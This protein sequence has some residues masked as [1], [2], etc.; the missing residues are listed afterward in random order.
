MRTPLV[1]IVIPAYNAEAYVREA[2]DSALAQ[3]YPNK[4]VIVVDDGS[5]DGTGA[6][7]QSYI[8]KKAIVYVRQDNKGL[9]SARNTGMR[10]ARGEYIALLDSDD[11]FLPD[12]IAR[13]VADLKAHPADDVSYCD[14]IH[15]YEEEPERALTLNYVYY[16]GEE[17]FPR[18]LVKNFINPLTVILRRS[19]IDRIGMFDEKYR[20]SEDWEY[21]IRLAYGG[22]RFRHLPESL[23]RYRM[24][25]GSLSYGWDSEVQ[26]KRTEV[27]IFVRLAGIMSA[28]E[29][30]K[31]G[32]DKVILGHRGKLWY[33]EI[34]QYFP[35]L[36]WAHQWIQKRR[37]Q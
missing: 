34:A 28:E 19:A 36:K 14:V 20:R 29:R 16:S 4:E 24:R 11:L 1:S 21:W 26:R 3:T 35:P 7:L 2:V 9:S 8:D 32:M 25:K 5:T 13:Q 15:F 22:V 23:A 27:S 18:L 10:N 17:V 31:Y 12:K 6:V 30:K 33:A 37:L